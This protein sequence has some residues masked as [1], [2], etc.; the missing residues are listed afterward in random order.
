[1]VVLETLVRTFL[2]EK[3]ENNLPGRRV[4][5]TATSGIAALNVG[6]TTL[7]SWS[8]IGD[9]RDASNFVA[10]DSGDKKYLNTLSVPL[11]LYLKLNCPV[12]LLKMLSPQLVNGFRGKVFLRIPL[13]FIL[14]AYRKM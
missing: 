1:M 3:I 13:L 8:G 7:H 9:G 12:L 10:E 11:V 2:G 6:G 14:I 5:L 4:A